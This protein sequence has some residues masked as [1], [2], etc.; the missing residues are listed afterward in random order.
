[1]DETLIASLIGTLE[2][3]LLPRI[4]QG[5]AGAWGR[6]NRIADA[7]LAM[8][9]SSDVDVASLPL[10]RVGALQ[11][12]YV[13]ARATRADAA[14]RACAIHTF[15]T[16]AK[17]AIGPRRSRPP[18]LRVPRQSVLPPPPTSHEMPAW[19]PA[20]RVL[21]GFRLVRP[22]A[23]GGLGSL[24]RA[25][26]LEDE[27]DP[28]APEVV[29]KVPHDPSA[30]AAHVPEEELLAAFRAEAS[31]LAAIPLH[32]N[33]A[34]IL[35]FDVAARP[36]PFL[37][38]ELVEGRTLEEEL[39]SGAMTSPH[40]LE[41]LDGVLAGLD[42]MHATGVGHLDVKPD[43]VI[44]RRKGGDA[45]LVDFGLSGRTVRKKCGNPLY[46]APEVWNDDRE[47]ESAFAADAYS[48]ACLAFETLT[49]TP[50]FDHEDLFALIR[51]HL[52]HDGWPPPLAALR[53]KPELRK[54]AEVL[55]RALRASPA[56]RTRVRM[57][58][59]EMR[60][61]APSVR[62]VTW[63]I[64]TPEKWTSTRYVGVDGGGEDDTL[65]HV[66][67]SGQE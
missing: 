36:K 11:S 51:S 46:A 25:Q 55:S 37:V 38:M 54:L 29:V 1:V 41:I 44:L 28:L 50:L 33:L 4:E 12:L 14:A 35:A 6:A 21:G 43:N 57:L 2:R 34:R 9:P 16:R 59:T 3:E 64:A 42:A 52:A 19:V 65:L 56:Q 62:D 13:V 22:M 7:V 23:S 48:F 58:R 8:L 45:T 17:D 30:L 47:P 24:F 26:R 5:E 40:A 39:A 66:A 15:V 32:P 60:R 61:L 49:G 10:Q 27:S 18:S 31:A 53:A 63:P 20:S 67:S